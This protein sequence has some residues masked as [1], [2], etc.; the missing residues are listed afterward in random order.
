MG[1]PIPAAMLNP[2]G[3]GE[4]GLDRTPGPE[5]ALDAFAAAAQRAPRRRCTVCNLPAEML[6]V[7]RENRR[8]AQP[9]PHRVVSQF[10]ASRGHRVTPNMI[11]DHFVLGHEE[12]R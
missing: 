6:E 1:T 3:A 8:R 4:L 9:H 11:R 2:E 5:N 10:L 12:T 7:V